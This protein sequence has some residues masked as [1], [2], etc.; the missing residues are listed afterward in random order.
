M[1]TPALLAVLLAGV[2]MACS[3]TDMTTLSES[4]QAFLRSVQDQA[5]QA[6]ESILS[7]EEV[8]PAVKDLVKEVQRSGDQ[9]AVQGK[10]LIGDVSQTVEDNPSAKALID[11]AQEAIDK[12]DAKAQARA[13]IQAAI[14]QREAL[15]KAAQ[16]QIDTGTNPEVIKL[17]ENVKKEQ[18]ALIQELRTRL[19]QLS[20]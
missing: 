18:G 16:V 6:P 9:L 7:N 11:Q 4:D 15:I 19:E 2:L 13:W 14:H 12:S 10:H 1:R 3:G 8:D 20:K 17:A 5:V